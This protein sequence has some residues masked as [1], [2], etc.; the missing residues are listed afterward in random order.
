MNRFR[1]DVISLLKSLTGG[2]ELTIR[3]KYLEIS[4]KGIVS[5]VTLIWIVLIVRLL[6]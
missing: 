1:R 5:M 3:S 2:C 4:A 6:R